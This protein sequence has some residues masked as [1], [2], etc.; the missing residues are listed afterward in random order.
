MWTSEILSETTTEWRLI[1]DRGGSGDDA[2]MTTAEILEGLQ[3][4]RAEIVLT[5]T[6]G[7][8]V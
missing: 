7:G 8:S 2:M 5:S 4:N 1:A 3:R 6:I